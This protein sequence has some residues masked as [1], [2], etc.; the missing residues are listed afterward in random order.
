M[1]SLS[2]P[3]RRS[4]PKTLTD[5]FPLTDH[6]KQRK[7]IQQAK[8]LTIGPL[9]HPRNAFSSRDFFQYVARKNVLDDIGLV[10]AI[11]RLCAELTQRVGVPIALD[12]GG[13]DDNQRLPPE[14]ETVAYR[15][16]AEALTNVVRHAAA[17]VASVTFVFEEDGLRATVVDDGVGFTANAEVLRSMGLAGMAERAS[18]AGGHL[19]I[20]ST[21]DEGTTVTLTVPL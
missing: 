20:D 12:F 7:K 19:D 9:H 4:A 5:F 3:E 8:R 14:V 10:A 2:K 18:L 21:P 11:D 16:V 15:V 17:S 1:K 13:L 6:Y